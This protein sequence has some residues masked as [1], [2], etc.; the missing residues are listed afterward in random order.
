[1]RRNISLW[2]GLQAKLLYFTE[3]RGARAALARNLGVARQA[4]SSWLSGAV[5]PNAETT[6]RLL[7]WV[8]EAEASQQKQSAGASTPAR[9]TRKSKSKRYEKTKSSQKKQ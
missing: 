2:G 3:K 1:M 7:E 9:K 6:L 8:E 4:V 5:S